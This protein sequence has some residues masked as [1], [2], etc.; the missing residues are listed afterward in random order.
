M[1]V[2]LFPR[3]SLAVKSAR[4]KQ[5]ED[6]TTCVLGIDLGTS[7]LK[8]VAVRRDGRVIASARHAYPTVSASAG[9]AEQDC[10]AWLKSLS[11]ASKTVNSS[12]RQKSRVEAIA[13]TGQMP[14]LVVLRKNKAIGPAI[15]WQD[16][17]A[18]HWVSTRVDSQFRSHVYL[19]TGV[20]IDGRYLA[21]MFQFHHGASERRAD[22][23]L[24]AKDFVFHAL[25]GQAVTDPSTASGYG[26]YNLRSQ[27]WDE[28]LC[29]FWNIGAECLPMVKSSDFSAPLRQ[30]GSTILGCSPGTPVILG[31]ADSAAGVYAI[32]GDDPTAL[33]VI[34]GS[35]TVIMKSDSTPVWDSLSRY[36]VTPLARHGTYGREADLLA[37]GSAR[38]W[39]EHIL[40]ASEKKSS[41]ALWRAAYDVPPGANGLLFA[42]YLAGG[43]QGILWSPDLQGTLRG[44]TLDHDPGHIARALLEGMF[45]E[46]RRSIEPFGQEQ[47]LSHV[48]CTGWIA[49]IPAELQLLADVLGKPVHAYKL[50]SASAMGAALVSGLINKDK[51]QENTKATVFQPTQQSTLYNIIYGRYLVQFP[52]RHGE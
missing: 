41:R 13:L 49:A 10:D 23:L 34:T 48:R 44:L 52:T 37:S 50:D 26:L 3:K 5:T 12:L 9:Q 8:L 18:D 38:A 19:Q 16:S 1:K 22:L 20:L 21:P 4:S 42:P 29:K 15:T 32:D 6:R 27:V 24:S 39:A 47:P 40:W 11:L 33:A 31:C 51:Y 25:T 7:A 17:R 43:E 36:L 14:T 45:F 30:V 2:R 46:I 35:S 28:E